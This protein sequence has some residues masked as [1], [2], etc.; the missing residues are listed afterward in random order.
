MSTHQ[1]QVLVVEDD[2][3]SRQLLES[4][5][6]KWGY[7]AIVAKDGL[8]AWQVLR[9][10]DGPQLCLIDWMMPR[11]DGIQLSKKIRTELA[12]R[13]HYL[14]LVTVANK[15]DNVKE[16][17][18]AGADDYVTKPYDAIELETR[19]R[20]GARIVWLNQCLEHATRD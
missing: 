5:V 16:G 9:E 15:R 20:I 12:H 6:Q 7:Q 18:E 11:L 13:F 14:L 3:T 17:F 4:L 1:T 10:G 2:L 8:E 19:L